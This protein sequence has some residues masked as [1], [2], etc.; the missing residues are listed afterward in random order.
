MHCSDN[1]INVMKCVDNKGVKCWIV[2]DGHRCFVLV[3]KRVLDAGISE[4]MFI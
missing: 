3:F 4:G 1:Q 2:I